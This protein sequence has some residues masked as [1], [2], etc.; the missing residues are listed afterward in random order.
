[1]RSPTTTP[2][3]GCMRAAALACLDDNNV[4]DIYAYGTLTVS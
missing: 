4:Y 3:M 1:M 2:G